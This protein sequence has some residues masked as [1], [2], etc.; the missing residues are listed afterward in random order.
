[1][2]DRSRSSLSPFDDV[3]IKIRTD[4]ANAETTGTEQRHSVLL[5]LNKH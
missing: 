3:F 4:G 1:M 5:N 2:A